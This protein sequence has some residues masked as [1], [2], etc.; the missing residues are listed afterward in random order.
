MYCFNWTKEELRIF[1]LLEH[2]R[3]EEVIEA[4]KKILE[5]ENG[6]D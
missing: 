1:E 2:G 5:E 3:Y 6:T 4:C